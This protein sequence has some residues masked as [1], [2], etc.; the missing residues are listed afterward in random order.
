[1]IRKFTLKTALI[2]IFGLLFLQAFSQNQPKDK[3]EWFADAKLG[4][5]IHW[6][7]YSVNGISESWSFFNNYIPYKD[8]KD[9]INHFTA[10]NYDPKYWAELIRQSG[11]KYSVIT[12]KHHEGVS[13]W[14][15][16]QP[17]AL[18]IPGHSP[19][20]RDVL[21]PFIQEL[22]KTGLKTGLYY[23]LPDWSYNDY[24]VFTSAI[25]RYDIN[26]EPAR[27]ERF[28]NYYQG[29]LKE[30]SAQYKPDLIWFDGDWE[31]TAEEWKAKET[32]EL[33]QSYNPAIILN[34]RLKGHGDYATPEQGVPV[35]QPESQ[36]WELCYTMNDSW[37]YQ[38]LDKKYKSS[39]MLIRTLVDCISLGGNLL[40]DIGP[41]ADGTIPAEQ[42]KILQDLG[43]W[44][45]KHAEAV[46]GTRHGIDQKHFDGK[47]ALSKDSKTLFLYLADNPNGLVWLKG[48]ESKIKH[49][50]VVGT[51][52]N[53]SY[54]KEGNNFW[55][56]VPANVVDKDVTV[57]RV[58]FDEPLKLANEVITP[59][60][61]G[62]YLNATHET[63]MKV[64]KRLSHDV[65]N[66]NNPFAGKGLAVNKYEAIDFI[67]DAAV[68]KWITKHAEVLGN[69]I[70]GI[71]GGHFA[72]PTALS[73]DKQ[74]LYLFIEGKS[75]G[76]VLLKG[77]NNNIARIRI[78]GEGSIIN[79]YTIYD[80]LYW[81][82]TPGIISIQVPKERLDAHVTVIAV[83][84]DSPVSLFRSEVKP[85][86]SNL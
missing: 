24:D 80:K 49:I 29:Q 84:L 9:Q 65:S 54:V 55:I 77:I 71:D 56:T 19:A 50:D 22:K 13:L 53:L 35:Q 82:A 39:N 75:N 23:S 43:R 27:F 68:K 66:G 14:D 30:L 63:T 81:S 6:G 1:M 48:I 36:Y 17:G 58:S 79:D 11:A 28:I 70:K 83:L 52:T 37:G 33:L 32:R 31:H 44:T 61:A 42:I 26:K 46:Y 5:F 16:R 10:K 64:L 57:L 60:S 25:K 74:T 38:P 4:I 72:G 85:I 69:G 78:V 8:Y 73:P 2:F 34:S 15:N 7:I 76:Q 21:T 59:V 47:S 67:K 18:S 86:E 62:T 3:M 12:T 40:L 20:K 41:K 45:S 51:K